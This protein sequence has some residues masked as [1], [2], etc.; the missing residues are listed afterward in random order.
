V[1]ENSYRIPKISRSFAVSNSALD[2]EL[3][4]EYG[5]LNERVMRPGNKNLGGVKIS[6]NVDDR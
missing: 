4:R 5:G 3:M 2:A 6:E 1:N